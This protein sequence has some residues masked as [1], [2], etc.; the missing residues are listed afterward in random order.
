MAEQQLEIK[1]EDRGAT[2]EVGIKHGSVSVGL[3]INRPVNELEL[4][5]VIGAL[6]T[7]VAAVLDQIGA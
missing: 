4:Q 1:Y 3:V 5:T 2:I 6:P 7:A